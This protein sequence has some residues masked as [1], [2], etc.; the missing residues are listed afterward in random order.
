MAEDVAS[1]DSLP[2]HNGHQSSSRRIFASPQGCPVEA[3]KL[4]ACWRFSFLERA[5]ILDQINQFLCGYRLLQAGGHDRELLFRAF[6][7]VGLFTASNITPD[8]FDRQLI[9]G[10]AGD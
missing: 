1:E 6:E 10:F 7:D 2:A 4:T 5:Q 9:R 8:G 3:R